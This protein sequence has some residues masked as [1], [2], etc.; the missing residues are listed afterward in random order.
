MFV[1]VNDMA[2][3]INNFLSG[4]PRADAASEVQTSI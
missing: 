4:L 3:D 2:L 1:N